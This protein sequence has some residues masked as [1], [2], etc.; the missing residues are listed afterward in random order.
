M[1][2]SA[3]AWRPSSVPP[4]VRRMRSGS[5]PIDNGLQAKADVEL[6]LSKVESNHRTQ[7]YQGNGHPNH[8]QP[9]RKN[10]PAEPELHYSRSASESLVGHRS[11]RPSRR[12]RGAI[13]L[14][15]RSGRPLTTAGTPIAHEPPLIAVMPQAETGAH[16]NAF[17][18]GT[19]EG[20]PCRTC[21]SYSR[22]LC[23][24]HWRLDRVKSPLSPRNEYPRDRLLTLREGYRGH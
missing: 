13:S 18:R 5:V 4:P 10:L 15:R 1:R 9:R 17:D 3:W 16:R 8:G 7:H 14:F 20:S 11:R 2:G 12:N 22:A 19:R 21:G 23:T 6:D 24:R